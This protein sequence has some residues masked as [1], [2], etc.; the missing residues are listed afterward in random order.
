MPTKQ[1]KIRF[2]FIEV[3]GYWRGFF[4]NQDIQEQFN[5]SRQHAYTDINLYLKMHPNAVKKLKVGYQFTDEYLAIL[6]MKPAVNNHSLFLNWFHDKTF[7]SG[8]VENHYALP[9]HQVS[10]MVIQTLTLAMTQQKRVDIDYISL[11]SPDQDGRIFHPHSFFKTGLRWYVR[12]YCEKSRKYRDLILSRCQGD[13]E[14]LDDSFRPVETDVYW[15]QFIDVIFEPIPSL[16]DKQK[17][18][19]HQEFNMQDGQLC[20]SIRVPLVRYF[21]N[22]LQF[23]LHE[24]TPVSHTQQ[25]ILK[26]KF[27]LADILQLHQSPH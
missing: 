2:L 24:E 19:V 8:I 17:K 22:D 18:V 5:L 7:T 16:S 14:L 23:S 26:N 15:N 9:N 12:G 13:I 1:Q 6:K 3:L 20:V 27:A 10:R 4:K 11:N 25:I 21:L